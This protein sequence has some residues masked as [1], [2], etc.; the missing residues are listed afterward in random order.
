MNQSPDNVEFSYKNWRAG[1]LRVT[2]IGACVFGLAALIP[3]ITTASTLAYAAIYIGLYLALL[4]VAVLNFPYSVKA[5]IFIGLIFLLGVSGLLETGIWGDSRLFM[6]GAIAMASLLFS[7]KVGWGF[8]GLTMLSY[9]ISGWLVLSGAMT[10]SN[11]DVPEGGI[12]IW[13]SGSTAVL[14]LAVLIINGIR[15]M[16]DEFGKAESLAQATL[17]VLRDE[18]VTLEQR[19]ENRTQDLANANQ[20][21][22]YRA[23]MFQAIAEVTRAII[24]TQ[25]LQDLLPQITQAI[26]QHFGLYHIGIFL[27]DQ[28]REYA[29]LSAANSEGGQRMLDRNHK[30]RVGQVGIVGY[31]A[32]TGKPR[33]ALDTGTDAI[34]FT[35]PD[36]PETRSEMAL[37]LIQTNGQV[38]GVLDIQS[39]EPNAFKHEDIEILITLADQVSVAIANAR[40]YE[41]TQKNLIEA[42]MLY[43]RDLQ[44][45]WRKFTD[46]QK[47]AG[48]HRTGT[49][50]SIYAEAMD[51]PG[52]AEVI[53]S[54]AARLNYDGSNPQ[55]MIP[56]KLRGEVVGI[57]NVKTDENRKW[58]SDEM[59]IVTAIVERA[60][61]A[62][63]NTRLLTESQKSA[64][65][66][67]VIGEISA[68]IGASTQIETILRT[69]IQELGNTLADTDIAIQFRGNRETE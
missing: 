4:L 20:V 22:E 66:E 23:R 59:D 41:E 38:V 10:I 47:I 32:G 45:G 21:N 67:R 69:T 13:A 1:F 58:T 25:N 51:L 24:S 15:L 5:G 30:L 62:I 50:T 44:T 52:A 27:L 48:I 3:G 31:V 8:T 2:L 6:L 36:L 11:P 68:R 28:S 57:L 55:M 49:S 42:Q 16:Q 40:L 12:D 29:I 63:E 65:K 7:W 54:G 34:Y 61:L 14:L 19:V 46:L 35:N 26:S 37:P 56:V 60:A 17:D 33:I 43:R 53:N 64:E 39:T 9:L 18:K